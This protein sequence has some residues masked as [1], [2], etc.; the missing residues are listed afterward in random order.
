MK[1][2]DSD[3]EEGGKIL[4]GVVAKAEGK[5]RSMQAK[6][7]GA[8][9]QAAL[10]SGN[11]EKAMP[12]LER[13]ASEFGDT[14]GAGDSVGMLLML[15]LGRQ[16]DDFDGALAFAADLRKKAKDGKLP[17]AAERMIAQ[18]HTAAAG[19]AL[20][21]AAVGEEDPQVL[22]ELAWTAYS[23]HLAMPKAVAWA[24]KAAEKSQRDPMI[25]D[26]LA[27]LLFETG[28]VEEAVKTELEAMEKVEGARPEGRVRRDAREVQGG[29]RGASG[30]AQAGHG[31]TSATSTAPAPEK[32]PEPAKPAGDPK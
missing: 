7:L 3:P 9:A 28:K 15:K 23:Q 13:V 24:T 10:Q 5:D 27:N 29:D 16:R 11:A 8:M 25:L 31:A 18:I 12:L 22:N 20:E 4:E 19:R 6:A 26:T 17:S 21:R 32:K 1:L 30:A 14:D 2:L